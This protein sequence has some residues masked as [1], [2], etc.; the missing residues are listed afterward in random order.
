MPTNKLP[1]LIDKSILQYN[2]NDWNLVLLASLVLL[3]K[4]KIDV[5]LI[6][7][8]LDFYGKRLVGISLSCKTLLSLETNA[9]FCIAL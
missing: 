1:W 6:S 5:F 8:V 3:N 7:C 4:S 2:I 9:C